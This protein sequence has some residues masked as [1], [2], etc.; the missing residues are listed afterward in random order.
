MKEQREHGGGS[1]FSRYGI[2]RKSFGQACSPGPRKIY[3]YKGTCPS[4]ATRWGLD[5]N[6]ESPAVYQNGRA[7][8]WLSGVNNRR[9]GQFDLGRPARCSEMSRW[10][11]TAARRAIL[12]VPNVA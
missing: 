10:R 12:S 6:D 4:E 9:A 2:R 3:I 7:P 11:I 8:M 5:S 1:L